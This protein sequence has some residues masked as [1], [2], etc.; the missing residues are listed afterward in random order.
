MQNEPQITFHG[1]DTSPALTTLVKEKIAKLEQFYGRATSCLVRIEKDTR[2]GQQGHLFRVSISLE[3]PIGTVVVSGKPGDINAHEDV[4]V[5]LRDSFDA[6]R[7]QLEDLARKSGRVHVKRH[8]ERVHGEIVRL[9]PDEGYGFIKL[10]NDEEAFFH[11][12]SVTGAGWDTLDLGSS[13]TFTL[14]DGDKGYYAAN[15]TVRS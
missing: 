12:D 1:L 9:F 11:R 8:P 4:R 2:K 3:L 14:M 7:S 10:S 15:V 13:V 5:A 6:A